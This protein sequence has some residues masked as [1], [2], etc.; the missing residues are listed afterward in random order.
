V[1]VEQGEPV[2]AAEDGRVCLPLP[3][4]AQ[5]GGLPDDDRSRYIVVQIAN[6]ASRGPLV[7]HLYD[8]G[9]TR[10]LQLVALERPD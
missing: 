8:L 10:G 5:D 7:A 1:K 9:P 3:S 2:A 6:G 4:R